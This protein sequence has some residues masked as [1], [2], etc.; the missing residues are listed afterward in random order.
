MDTLFKPENSWYN[1][2]VDQRKSPKYETPYCTS[3]S[4][5]GGGARGQNLEHPEFVFFLFLNRNNLG[6]WLVIHLL[7][8]RH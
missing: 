8:L 7:T 5:L 2:Q 4:E 3:R 6:R 1:N